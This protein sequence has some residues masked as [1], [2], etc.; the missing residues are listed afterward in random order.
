MT[1]DSCPKC[2]VLVGQNVCYQFSKKK[3]KKINT[4]LETVLLTDKSGVPSK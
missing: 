4:N 2:C 3:K 1:R